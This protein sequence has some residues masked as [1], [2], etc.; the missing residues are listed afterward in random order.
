MV[1]GA[2]GKEAIN[3]LFPQIL[4]CR[5]LVGKY[6]FCRKNFVKMQNFGLKLK[7]TF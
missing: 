5:K 2:R 7:Q 3:F 6:A 1:Q 4:G